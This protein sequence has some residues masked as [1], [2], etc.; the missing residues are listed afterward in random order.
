MLKYRF[1]SIVCAGLERA[2]QW[3]A[4]ND[5]LC[6]AECAVLGLFIVVGCTLA[7]PTPN[8]NEP[9]RSFVC[10]VAIYSQPASQRQPAADDA[11]HAVC[12]Q[13]VS[14]ARSFAHSFARLRYVCA[15][16]ML[17]Y[18]DIRTQ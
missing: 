13:R 2:P 5:E 8:T 12:T 4:S 10:A 16:E 18:I 17:K 15:F 6:R 7:V 14:S 9:T 3:L 11:V 1:A